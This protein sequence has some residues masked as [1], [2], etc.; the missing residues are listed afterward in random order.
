MKLSKLYGLAV[1][2][3]L[4]ALSVSV[5]TQADDGAGSS[6]A[7][8]SQQVQR[9]RHHRGFRLVKK[10]AKQLGIQ[11]PDRS[12]GGLR[13]LSQDQKQEIFACVKQDRQAIRSCLEAA[14]IPVPQRGQPRP[15]LTPE[16]K[17]AAKACVEKNS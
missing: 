1:F 17:A 6:G 4:F 10:C 12:A 15:S 5:P 8:S 3:A 16:Q 11:I 13:A 9:H 14:G 7:T 2:G